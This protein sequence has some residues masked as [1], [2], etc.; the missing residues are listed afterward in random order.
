MSGPTRTLQIIVGSLV[1]GCVVFGVVA[2][3]ALSPQNQRPDDRLP[4]MTYTAVAFTA[5]E[6]LAWLIVPAMI[7]TST[8][9][10]IAA[11]TWEPAGNR[12]P[13]AQWN[14]FIE[15]TGD[16]GRLAALFQTKTIIGA[17][18]FEGV[19]FLSIVA[20]MSE[21]TGLS[22]G[23]A[24]VLTAGVAFHFPTRSRLVRWIERQLQIVEQE[25]QLERP[26]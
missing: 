25:R 3:V 10:R 22:L 26:G 11:G 23:L 19:A 17:A 4:V 21:Q 13:A 12:Q 8:R 7:V 15:R 9:K 20:Y 14:D 18:L 24:G 6:I 5:M 16:A 2:V 1:I